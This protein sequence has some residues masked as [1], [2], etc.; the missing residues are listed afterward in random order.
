ML[1]AASKILAVKTGT[2][3]FTWPAGLVSPPAMFV[4]ATSTL[5]LLKWIF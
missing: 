2:S 5:V 1:M 4:P 3:L